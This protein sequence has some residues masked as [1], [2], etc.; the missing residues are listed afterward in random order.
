MSSRIRR[1][2]SAKRFKWVK[3]INPNKAVGIDNLAGRFV[4]DASDIIA[5]PITSLINL[6]IK[7]SQFPD[8]GKIA[9]LKPLYKKR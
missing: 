1:L 9:K 7:P 5:E 3:L 6:S 4:K 8:V 2:L